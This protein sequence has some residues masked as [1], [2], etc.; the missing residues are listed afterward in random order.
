VQRADG[1]LRHSGVAAALDDDEFGD[2]VPGAATA[3]MRFSYGRVR[4]AGGD[5]AT[6]S[7][8][9]GFFVSADSKGLGRST[10]VDA[11]GGGP[12]AR[13]DIRSSDW[14]VNLGR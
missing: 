4:G 6:A 14:A 1:V 7:T 11:E 3:G 9:P 12:T 2:V 5:V 8:P 13:R 10:F